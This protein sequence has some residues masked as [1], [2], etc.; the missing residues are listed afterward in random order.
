MGRSQREKGKRGER[1]L[2]AKLTEYFGEK[3][4]RGQQYCGVA[5]DADVVGLEGVHIE[6]KRV[7]MFSLYPSLEQADSDKKPG[8]VPV[9]C[10]R[11]NGKD[12]V[13]VVYLKDLM[14]LAEVLGRA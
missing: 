10:H 4:R 9:V 7:E 8:D 3:C 13:A 2:A 6:S 14:R 1:E 11:R 5:G 12:W